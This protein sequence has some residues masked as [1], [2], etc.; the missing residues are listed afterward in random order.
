MVAGIVLS[1]SKIE[2]GMT[3]A[4]PVTMSTAIVSPMARPIPSTTPDVIPE[5]EDGITTLYM[6]CYCVDPSARLASRMERGQL[7]I[8]SSA[9]VII[10]GKAMIA[11]MMLPANPDSPTGRSNEF[12][13]SGTMTASPKNP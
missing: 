11:N 7:L 6:V 1:G 2:V 9:T 4:L 13:N 3:A 8:A 12:C 5:I 10:V